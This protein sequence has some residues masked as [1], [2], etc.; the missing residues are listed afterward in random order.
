[1]RTVDYP[2][3]SV[4]TKGAVDSSVA[5]SV[6]PVVLTIENSQQNYEYEELK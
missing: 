3:V 6:K 1:M 4:S 2:L 5:L